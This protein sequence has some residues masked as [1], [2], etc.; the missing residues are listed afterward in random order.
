MTETT[1]SGPV[2]RLPEDLLRVQE[3]VAEEFRHHEGH[4][5]SRA[6]AETAEILRQR[7]YHLRATH[8][9]DP[10]VTALRNRC[11]TEGGAI[12][13]SASTVAAAALEEIAR[14][15]DPHPEEADRG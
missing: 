4:A 10:L 2:L 15:L 8:G 11:H 5:R 14:Q 1:T 12:H 7:A 6:L 3:I 13:A 9:T